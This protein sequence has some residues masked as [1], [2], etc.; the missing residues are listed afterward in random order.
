[1]IERRIDLKGKVQQFP[2]RERGILSDCMVKE[3]RTIWQMARARKIC[4][5]M[6]VLLFVSFMSPSHQ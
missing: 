6:Y 3:R 1:M 4:D 2:E 5:C